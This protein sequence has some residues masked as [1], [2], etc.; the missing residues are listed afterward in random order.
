MLEMDEEYEGNVEVH[1][2][3]ICFLFSC[4]GDYVLFTQVECKLLLNRP[5]AKISLLSLLKV[6][7][8]SELYL[9]LAL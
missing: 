8:L 5:L 6:D 1:T 9:M 7:G 3:S 2:W 4:E